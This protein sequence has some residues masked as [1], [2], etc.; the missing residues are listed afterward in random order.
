MESSELTPSGEV[1]TELTTSELT[2][3]GEVVNLGDP[4][5]DGIEGKTWVLGCALLGRGVLG[6]LGMGGLGL[7]N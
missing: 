7:Y 4:I 2:T 1:V 6:C 3:S 5:S